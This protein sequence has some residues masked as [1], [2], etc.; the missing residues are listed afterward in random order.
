MR[1]VIRGSGRIFAGTVTESIPYVGLVFLIL[2]TLVFVQQAGRYSQILLSFQAS[3]EV[4]LAFLLSML[5]GIAV[6]TLP[7]ALILGTVIT[8]SRQSADN[9][10]TV[11][12]ASGMRPVVLG[13][14]FLLVGVAGMLMSL[15]L[16]CELAPRSLKRLKALRSRIL[17]EEATL[18]I[19][20][21]MFITT[22][23]DI[24][25]Y[26]QEIDER[27]GDW[28]GVFIL[29]EE[30]S[31]RADRLTRVVT[32]ERG[33]L[34]VANT[35]RFSLEADLYRGI[36]LE[37]DGGGGREVAVE[38]ASDF[39]KASIRLTEK[40]TPGDDFGEAAGS[41]TEMTLSELD[42]QS[43]S[44]PGRER[45]RARVEWHRRLAFPFACLTLTAIA[46]LVS[47]RGRRFSTRPRTVVSILF[48]ALAYYLLMVFGQNLA[49]SGKL[50]AWIGVWLSNILAGVWILAAL[51]SP[52]GTISLPFADRLQALAA[53]LRARLRLGAKPRE[54][55]PAETRIETGAEGVSASAATGWPRFSLFS[56]INYLIVTEIGKYFLLALLA[57][58]VT[59]VTFTL[60]DLIPALAKS[61]QTYGYAMSYLGYLSPQIAYHAAPF[62]L[63]VA[64]LAGGS[65][66][67]RSQQFVVLGASGVGRP[68]ILAVI[69]MTA[70]VA[71]L[72]L[73]LFSET[74]LPG[75]NR[76][77]DLRYHRIKN[78]QLEQTTIAFDR[79]WVF[80]KNHTIYG[81]QRI[82]ADNRL[83]NL[84]VY[85]LSEDRHLLERR[86]F[87]PRARQLDERRWLPEGG[88]AENIRKDLTLDRVSLG[89]GRTILGIE[90][91]PSL[92]RRT[93]NE[94]TKMSS[95]ELRE[96]IGQ[97]RR[98]GIEST[99]FDL[100]LQKRLALPF[101]CLTLGLLAVPFATTRR[102]RRASPLVSVAI[103][104]FISLIMWLLMG[105]LEAAGRGSS[106]PVTVAVWSPQ[107][108][109]LAIGALLNI[110]ERTD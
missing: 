49:S 4:A 57:L 29:Q 65:V 53:R 46:F 82:E 33:R 7:L 28:V 6:I 24:L 69:L 43:R 71:G 107:L 91:G 94:S 62:A 55:Q 56:L 93:V 109:F 103:G 50:P 18:R 8:C 92:F 74:I 17:L 45:L 52:R 95:E 85:Q 102:A 67:A 60:F 13:L 39:Q 30:G 73:W 76:E 32:A 89:D 87:T 68:R 42:R 105:I 79:K 37:T 59:S 108:L 110:R 96:H 10:L 5:P 27:T 34:R 20:P 21:H 72:G 22:F 23:P 41:L 63:M 1:R 66:L 99:E 80:G 64:I 31:G 11:A 51:S 90:D 104:V 12:Q 98:I 35:G 97:L 83:T 54:R 84:V 61:G 70:G 14:P 15:Y 48:A 106:L 81:Y 78:K 2:T 25:L 9:E 44:G 26:V 86:V 47:V 3:G 58:V 19:R 38:S 40:L 75:T 16:T 100:D 88:E 101:S 36:S 77:Q